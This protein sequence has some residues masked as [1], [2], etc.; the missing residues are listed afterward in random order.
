MKLSSLVSLV[1][2]AGGLTA[3][4]PSHA[5]A[6]NC[7]NCGQHASQPM[8]QA[9]QGNGT[10][11]IM[12]APPNPNAAS[13]PGYNK[14]DRFYTAVVI[15]PYSDTVTGFDCNWQPV[16]SRCYGAPVLRKY[17]WEM[18]WCCE[19]GRMVLKPLWT[20]I[21]EDCPV[22]TQG[23]S[24]QQQSAPPTTQGAPTGGSVGT[25]TGPAVQPAPGA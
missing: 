21:S 13:L 25:I 5:F 6:Q 9:V 7:A 24:S 23:T 3:L 20:G 10:P 15:Q 2:A 1:L 17:L 14:G 18:Q 22:P 19:G 11:S 4:G 12:Q 8:V 16:V